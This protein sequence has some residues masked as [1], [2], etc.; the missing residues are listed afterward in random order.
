MEKWMVAAKKADFKAIGERFGIDQVVARLIRNRGIVGE[1]NIRI[2]LQGTLADLPDARQMKDLEKLVGILA[3]KIRQHA[4]IRVI[5]DYDADGVMSSFILQ[6]ALARAGAEADVVIPHRVY[7]GYGLNLRLIEKAGADGVDTILTCDN[8]IAAL[9]EIAYAKEQGMTVLVT[10]HHAIPFTEKDGV[11]TECVSVADAVVNPHQSA[12]PYPYKDLCGAGVAWLMIRVL[13]EELGID[14]RE[15]EELLQ[16]V[17]LA[18]VCDVMP[19]TGVNRILVREGLKNIHHTKN[20]GMQ[21]LIKACELEQERIDTYHFGFVLGPCVNATGRLDTARRALA[22]LSSEDPDQAAKI[23]GELVELNNER[24]EMTN[25]SVELAH[26]MIAAGDY[27]NDPVLVLYMPEVHESIAGLIA[28]RIR[29]SYSRPTFILTRGEEGAKGSGRSTEDYNMH[30]QMCKCSD[31]FTHFGGHPMAA[32]L[33]LPEENIPLFRERINAC[34]PLTVE[35]LAAKVHI[36]MQMPV[37]YATMALQQQFSCLAPFGKDNPSPL[38]VDKDLSVRRLRW[39][40]ENHSGV[41]VELCSADGTRMSAICWSPENFMEYFSEKYGENA[42]D[43][44]LAG[45]ENPIR[46]AMVYVL[47]INTYQGVENLQFEIKYYR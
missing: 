12:C 5:G 11:K 44:A 29:E 38:F 15:A 30:E 20:I 37:G 4:K 1:E 26:Q 16:F 24:K 7:D 10:D 2:Y 18:T 31:L 17:A 19:L 8:G 42:V 13:Y 36:D 39:L 34:C 21:A 33:S 6:Q 28:G 46:L 32:G 41:R 9:D 14:R 43:L 45:R 23:A 35:E 40:G 47:K 27:E 25:V 3:G 22:L